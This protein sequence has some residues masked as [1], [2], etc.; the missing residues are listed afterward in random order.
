MNIK[1]ISFKAT[2]SHSRSQEERVDHEESD[3]DID[4]KTISLIVNKLGKFLRYNGGF[5]NFHKEYAKY[6]IKKNKHP[7]DKTTCHECGN[8]GHIR[9]T[10]PTYLKRIEHNYKEDSRDIKAKKA[11]IICDEPEEKYYI[12]MHIGR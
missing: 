5:R 9:Y 4:D 1:G 12:K 6:S 7:K 2:N 11:Y 10:C 3:S 8:V